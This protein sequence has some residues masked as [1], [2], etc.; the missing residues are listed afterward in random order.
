MEGM[1]EAKDYMTKYNNPNITSHAVFISFTVAPPI[2]EKTNTNL[3]YVNNKIG[4]SPI[5]PAHA[6]IALFHE[7]GHA[8]QWATIAT[9]HQSPNN[10]ATNK[11]LELMNA[12]TARINT[13][14]EMYALQGWN[15][16]LRGQADPEICAA[17]KD[18][19]ISADQFQI[20]VD[21]G[22]Q[23]GLDNRDV[24]QHA[25]KKSG[26]FAMKSLI[27]G[28][29]KSFEEHYARQ[30]IDEYKN[31]QYLKDPTSNVVYKRLGPDARK[32]GAISGVQCLDHDGYDSAQSLRTRL[33]MTILS[34]IDEFNAKHG[35]DLKS[36]RTADEE[37]RREGLSLEGYLKN[38]QNF[39]RISA[40]DRPCDWWKD[41]KFIDLSQL[42][43]A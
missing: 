10:A 37:I 27:K 4:N 8:I 25:L 43:A 15:S 1:S 14:K 34:E 7:K 3:I 13:E 2:G 20:F 9:L 31:S 5:S 26:D 19:V 38:S 40:S 12:I 29:G 35:V 6:E 16:W 21:E 33:P 23:A 30:V 11:C 41:Y 28:K 24:L 17:S 18:H 32:I 42:T 36:I 22:M 39:T